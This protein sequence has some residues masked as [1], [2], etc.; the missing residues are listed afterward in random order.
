MNYE[1][2]ETFSPAPVASQL[3][4]RRR[5]RQL[6]VLHALRA[7]TS[8]LIDV[9]KTAFL[10]SA[11]PQARQMKKLAVTIGTLLCAGIVLFLLL[12][13][14]QPTYHGRTITAWEDA[15]A[16]NKTPEW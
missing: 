5:H 2:R 3:W 8:I 11:G 16:A 9:R 15:W 14:P 1:G 10:T 7:E 12:P 4:A 13:R 6:P